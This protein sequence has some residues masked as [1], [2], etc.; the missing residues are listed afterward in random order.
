M[1]KVISALV[2]FMFVFCLAGCKFGVAGVSI[3]GVY[4]SPDQYSAG[5]FTY[6]GSGI[7]TVEVN[8]FGGEIEIVQRETAA[9]SVSESG[10]SLKAGEQLHHYIKADKLIIQY[11]KSGHIG[12]IDE[13]KKKLRVEIPAGIDLNI[14]NTSATISMGTVSIDDCTII[15][16]SG[17]V[18]LASVSADE[19]E[20]DIVSGS[21]N[22]D[23]IF[24]RDFDVNGVSGSVSVKNISADEIG[25]KIVSGKTTLSLAKV[26]EVD[27]S[28]VGGD[29]NITLPEGAGA[30]VEF[31]SAGGKLHS[32]KSYIKNGKIY[33][34]GAGEVKVDVETVG[35]NL[36]IK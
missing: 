25:V 3:Y 17:G 35:G 10:G 20:I 29:V 7:K 18:N 2:I 28:G 12:E 21:V 33:T 32:D 31:E 16:V 13:E 4:A 11:C 22:A 24:V 34:F 6:D 26:C 8:W 30:E 14:N 19:V 9:L 36:Y 5:N 15:T 1:K 27:V 23:S